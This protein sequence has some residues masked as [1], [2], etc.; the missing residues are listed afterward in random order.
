[1]VGEEE[2]PPVVGIG[3]AAGGGE[4]MGKILTGE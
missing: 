1:V 4:R 3:G 2:G